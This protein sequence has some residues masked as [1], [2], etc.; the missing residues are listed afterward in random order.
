MKMVKAHFEAMAK[1]EMATADEN[2]KYYTNEALGGFGEDTDPLTVKQKQ[3]L[4]WLDAN[5]NKGVCALD[6]GM[7]KTATSIAIM[8]K[9][10]RDGLMD[11]PDAGNGRYLY[12]CPTALKGNLAK[13][14]EK[15]LV[16]PGAMIDRVDVMSYD[17]FRRARGKMVKK[18]VTDRGSRSFGKM[19]EQ[20]EPTSFGE[21]YIAVFFDEAQALKNPGS[22]RS[23]AAASLNHPRKVLLTASPMERS[24][25]EVY[26]LQA[27]SNNVDLTKS[28]ERKKMAE[29]KKQFAESVGGRVVG[30][31]SDNPDILR[32]FRVWVKQNLY[33]A[34]KQDPQAVALPDLKTDGG[35]P[36]QMTPEIEQQYRAIAKSIAKRLA[37]V[38]RS[39]KGRLRKKRDEETAEDYAAYKESVLSRARQLAVES[40][41]AGKTG[42]SR[43]FGELTRLSNIPNWEF[44][45][46]PAPTAKNPDATKRVWTRIPGLPNPKVDLAVSKVEERIETGN[47]TLL[48]TDSPQMATES[49]IR[50]SEQF[51]RATHLVGYSNKIEVFR[52]GEVVHTYTPRAY[53]NFVT[54]EDYDR[55]EWKVPVLQSLMRGVDPTN[56]TK[57][58]VIPATATLTGSY[59]VGQN[60]QMFS[61][62]VHLDRDT[63]NAETMKQRTARAWR[64]GQNENVEE[65]TLDMAYSETRQK[66]DE[67]L[68]ET[69]KA[70]QEMDS[71]LFD[72][73]VVQ[74]QSQDLG[75][76]WLTMKRNESELHEVNRQMIE[77]AMSPYLAR[78]GEEE[79]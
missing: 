61:T 63:W 79:R 66:T 41:R 73:V 59:A 68:D 12:V 23:M 45:D 10:K 69:R 5:G 48:F 72:E 70:I 18:K 29:F 40:L 76:E 78:M 34:D 77:M 53:P 65:Y 16:D 74:S 49:G 54:G 50:M 64:S 56:E 2:L 42:L 39:F 4:A 22:Q 37:Q 38:A 58:V 32:E 1:A 15:W 51:P 71:R 3:A 11:D 14:L 43:E 19:R 20:W 67:T 46:V 75:V 24:P 30:V 8:Q 60:L 7:G 31:R 17:E 21:D 27:I 13:E 33:F 9:L 44:E 36:V 47:K 57:K 55:S 25:M 52:G 6:T 35:T 62:V 28:A 26:A